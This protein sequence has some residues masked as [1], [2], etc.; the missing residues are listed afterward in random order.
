MFYQLHHIGSSEYI[1]KEYD[2]DFSYP[3]HMHTCFELVI[4]LEGKMDIS[5]N[6]EVYSVS[7][8][9]A[10]LIFPN[11]LHSFSSSESKHL[12]FIFSPK[13]VQSFAAKY[14]GKLPISSKFKLAENFISQLWE[15]TPSDSIIEIKGLFYSICARFEKNAEFKDF[16]QGNNNLLMQIFSFVD[17]NFQSE[18][19]LCDVARAIGYDHAYISRYF[20]KMTNMSY[21]GYVNVCRLNH[22]SFLLKNTD[23][24][25]L[26]CSVECG[27]KSLRSFNRNFKEYFSKTPQEYRLGSI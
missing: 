27:Y 1:K 13:I 7:R 23:L 14:T 8:G 18:C 19:A 12:L 10:V 11:Q 21:N 25:I 20:K 2:E 5:V 4:I 16:Y 9:E 17:K 26:E 6:D 15:L 24:S 22:A 3:L